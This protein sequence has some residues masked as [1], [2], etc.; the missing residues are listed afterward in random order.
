VSHST[1]SRRLRQI[2]TLRTQF[3]QADGLPFSDV[4]SAERVETAMEE[5][6]AHWREKIYTPLLTL[7]AFLS[8]VSSP[9]GSCRAI[10]ARVLAWR[11]SQKQQACTPE[12]DPYCKARQRIPETLLPRLTR[13]TGQA[14]HA[15]APEDWRWHGRRVKV[16][17][18]STVSMPDTLANQEEYPQNPTQAH[19]LGFPIARFVVVFCLACGTVIDSAIGRYQGKETGENSLL[20]TLANAFEPDDVL[21]GDRYYGGWFDL[22]LWRER[23]VDVVVRLHQMRSADFRRGC[24]VGTKDHV[25]AWP[26]PPKPDWMDEATYARLPDWLVVREV[27][28]RVEQPGFRTRALV[29]VTTLL[30]GETYPAPELAE[31]YRARWHAELDLRSLKIAMGMDVLR[32]KTPAMVRKEFWAH[33]LAYNLIRTVMAQTALDLEI[34]PRYLSF[35]G[36][37]Q[38]LNTFAERLLH[39]DAAA[40]V[41]LHEWLRLVIGT[42]LVGDR[43]DRLEPRA[44]KRRPKDYP[45]LH[46]PRHRARTFRYAKT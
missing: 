29:V 42:Y 41:E 39:A 4:L 38:A 26:K 32:C 1:P 20:R 30:D 36:A 8:Q 40:T 34:P 17:D 19:G 3:A 44:R 2:E 7:W 31:L 21:L 9:D 23:G 25:V 43:P 5:E 18:G 33:L 14:L 15:Q 28:V 13:E 27:A 37:M 11:V 12:T 46:K 24:R 45:N 16:V 10:V 6:K 35:K 22:A